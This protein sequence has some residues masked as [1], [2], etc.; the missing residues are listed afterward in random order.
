MQLPSSREHRRKR[1][2]EARALKQTEQA[3]RERLSA[4]LETNAKRE[5]QQWREQL[6][7]YAEKLVVLVACINSSDLYSEKQAIDI[8]VAAWQMG[9]LS[10]MRQLHSM[11]MEIYR[12]KYTRPMAV[13]YISIWWDGVGSW[14]CEWLEEVLS[15]A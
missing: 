1:L 10:C 5:R 13:D 12:W 7:P 15:S 14:R 9:G 11:A 3:E 6:L 2:A 8:G 4:E